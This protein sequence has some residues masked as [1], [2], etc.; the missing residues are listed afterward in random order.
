M[1][2]ELVEGCISGY[3]AVSL[4]PPNYQVQMGKESV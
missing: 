4:I 1:Y 3:D 2:I